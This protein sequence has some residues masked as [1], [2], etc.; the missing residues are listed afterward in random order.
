MRC[1]PIPSAARVGLP[2]LVVASGLLACGGP[3]LPGDGHHPKDSHDDGGGPDGSPGTPPPAENLWPLTTGST[4]RYRIT[5]PVR[6]VFEKRVTVLGPMD[7]PERGGRA[8]AVEST[9][10][11]LTERSWQLESGGLVVRLREEDERYGVPLRAAIWVPSTLKSLSAKQ[12]AGWSRSFTA[13]EIERLADG[14][15]KEEKDR[16]YVWKV[17]AVDEPVTT[18]AG[19]FEALKVTRERP[20]KPTYA[21]TYWL[22][23]GVGKVREEG[24]RTEE[25][26]EY[27]VK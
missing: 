20:D 7:V 22:V 8:I 4:W 12:P 27:Q 6:G 14:T 11:H 17:V 9:Q 10:P 21:R 1:Q 3:A 2:L 26:I 13:H 16:V 19:T 15:V 24:E 5:D 18:P 23:P 25:L